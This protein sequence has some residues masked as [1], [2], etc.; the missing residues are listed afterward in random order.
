MNMKINKLIK[1]SISL[2]FALS[3]TIITFAT[4]S[5]H[6][7]DCDKAKTYCEQAYAIKEDTESIIA[8]VEVL[9]V[10][11]DGTV[12]AKIL[13]KSPSVKIESGYLV[14]FEP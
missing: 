10:S 5:S 1:K 2:C 6:A 7:Y 8:D 14:K 4:T 12:Y 11:Q 9:T 3:L 13:G